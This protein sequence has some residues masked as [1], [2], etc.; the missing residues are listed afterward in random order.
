MSLQERINYLKEVIK[1]QDYYYYVLDKPQ[2][3]DEEYDSLFQEL[4]RL[5]EEHPDF[6]TSDSPNS[7]CWAQTFAI[8]STLF[9]SQQNV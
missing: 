7:A 1:K 9:S 6:R 3:T 5:E 2:M 4:L 8:I